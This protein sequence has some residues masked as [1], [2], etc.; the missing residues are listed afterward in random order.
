MVRLGGNEVGLAAARGEGG[1]GVAAGFVG[2]DGPVDHEH[3][4]AA[5]VANVLFVNEL[6]ADI[7]VAEVG[8]GGAVRG[9][10]EAVGGETEL[11]ALVYLAIS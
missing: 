10:V 1:V 8:A 4:G 3:H 5:L 11:D 9:G 6:V 7:E 2:G